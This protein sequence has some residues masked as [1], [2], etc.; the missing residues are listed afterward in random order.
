MGHRARSPSSFTTLL[1]RLHSVDLDEFDELHG[2]RHFADDK[3]I[4]GGVACPTVGPL[5]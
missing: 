1:P 5:W 3:A 4:V 2:D